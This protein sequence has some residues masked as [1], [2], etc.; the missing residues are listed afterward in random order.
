VSA[1]N[2]V[3]G[4]RVIYAWDLLWVLVMRDLKLRYRRSV[5]GILWSLATPLAQMLVFTFLFHRVVPL[6]IPNYPVFVFSGLLAWTWFQ[7]S[8]TM[9]AVSIT[10][11]RE[12]IGQ[13]GFPSSILPA[14]T[15]ATN[16]TH[17]LLELPVLLAFLLLS[18]ERPTGALF[19]LPLVIAVQYL[20]SLA[21]AYPI[22]AVNVAFRDTQH[23]ASLILLLLFYLTPVFYDARS[24]PAAYRPIFELNPMVQIIG[25][26]RSIFLHGEAPDLTWLLTFGVAAGVLLILGYIVFRRASVRFVEEL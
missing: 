16:L 2:V 8:T 14:V 1:V 3:R 9:A 19:A 21:I 26:Y 23:I 5:L 22:A 10:G 25:A 24:V 12:L 20:F 18:G 4:Q 17:F 6:G 7:T 13:P 15:V 11:N